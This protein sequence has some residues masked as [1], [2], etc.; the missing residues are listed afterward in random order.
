MKWHILTLSPRF[1][2]EH[3]IPSFA[4]EKQKKKRNSEIYQHSFFKNKMSYFQKT[5]LQKVRK[6][7]SKHSRYDHQKGNSHISVRPFTRVRTN[8]EARKES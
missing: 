3:K 7:M 2:R 4:L 1:D 5:N 6:T 8:M